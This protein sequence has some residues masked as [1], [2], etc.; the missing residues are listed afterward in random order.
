MAGR[1]GGEAGIW[2]GR[3]QFEFYSTTYAVDGAKMVTRSRERA[4]H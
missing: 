3:S 4:S 2:I 1:G